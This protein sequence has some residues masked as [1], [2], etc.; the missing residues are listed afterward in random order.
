MIEASPTGALVFRSQITDYKFR[1]DT[2]ADMSFVRFITDTW[3]TTYTAPKHTSQGGK[4]PGAPR[5]ERAQYLE[6]HPHSS[7]RERVLRAAGHNMLPNVVG[8][9]LPRSD[10]SETYDFYCASV[11]SLHKPWRNI[12]DILPPGQSWSTE[13]DLF[14]RTAEPKVLNFISGAQYYYQCK[15]AAARESEN[16]IATTTNGP[17]DEMD[18]PQINGAAGISHTPTEAELEEFILSQQNPREL[19][20][21]VE[22]ANIGMSVG[23]FKRNAE[24]SWVS[25]TASAHVVTE[26]DIRSIASWRESMLNDVVNRQTESIWKSVEI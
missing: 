24:Q 8:P 12:S 15:D 18:D 21:G 19:L 16:E 9:Y 5:H 6:G 11:L 3:E 2:F 25:S 23:L 22:A 17:D 14:L 1:G 10:H 26:A 13:L 20:H 7:T 4:T